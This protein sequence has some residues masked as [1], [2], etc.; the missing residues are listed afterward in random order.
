MGIL[1][2]EANLMKLYLYCIGQTEVP[3][4]WHQWSCL[5]LAASCLA[6]RVYYQKF[7]HSKLHPNMYIFLVGGSG[8]GKGVAIDYCMQFAPDDL[9]VKY[10]STTSKNMIDIMSTPSPM[11]N[12]PQKVML[13][14]PELADNV[15]SGLI[16]NMFIKFMTGAYTA[17]SRDFDEGTRKHGT[18]RIPQDYVINWLAG[19]TTEWLSEVV[20]VKAMQSGFFGRVMVAPGEYDYGKRVHDP[21][22]FRP[23][24]YAEVV[25]YLRDAFNNLM[26]VKG[27]FYMAADAYEN[28]RDWYKTRPMPDEDR[29]KPFWQR[30]QD[31][32]LKIAMVLSACESFDMIIK[33]RHLITARNLITQVRKRLPMVMSAAAGTQYT[34]SMRWVESY[35][36]RYVG[37]WV[38]RTDLARRARGVHINAKLLDQI[39]DD[40]LAMEIIT[41]DASGNKNSWRYMWSPQKYDDGFTD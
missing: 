10:G 28:E 36:K 31:A 12:E 20:D 17:G 35:L 8:E 37:E 5:S 32:I 1:D 7:G 21:L 22:E 40:L 19:T 26:R 27:R 29:M 2:R 16:A 18:K 34:G 11:V 3:M 14:Q 30:E 13:V 38:R 6:D 33:M 39:I 23:D 4:E 24:D 15:Q 9:F 25:E 41:M